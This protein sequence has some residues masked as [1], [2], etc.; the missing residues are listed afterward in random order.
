MQRARDD[1]EFRAKVREALASLDGSQM[2]SLMLITGFTEEEI[3]ALGGVHDDDGV[4]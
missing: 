1:D 2:Q 3:T 4:V